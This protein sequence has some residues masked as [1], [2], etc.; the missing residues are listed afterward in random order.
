MFSSMFNF[1]PFVKYKLPVRFSPVYFPAWIINAE[2]EAEVTYQGS[3]RN[4]TAILKSNYLP[5]SSVP[6]LSA[7]R[8]LP[9]GVDDREL[10][11]FTQSLMEQ[12]GLEVNCIPYNISPF[13]ILEIAKSLSYSQATINADLKF[14]PSSVKPHIFS[15]YPILLPLYLA[16]Y[17]MSY[18]NGHK[19]S[20]NIFIQAHSNGGMIMSENFLG[21]LDTPQL[22]AFE[23]LKGL[24]LNTGWADDTEVLEFGMADDSVQVASVSLSPQKDVTR[25]L[26]TY[27]EQPLRDSQNIDKLTEFGEIENDDDPRIRELTPGEVAGIDKYLDISLETM[28]SLSTAS[29]NQKVISISLGSTPKFEMANQ[30]QVTLKTKLEELEREKREAKPGW[31][32]EWEL[33]NRSPAS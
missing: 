32:V 8:L 29:E 20:L 13:S 2:V 21:K 33:G 18:L 11:L 14:S 26:D 23:S 5:G 15:A 31:W 30:A 17:E 1:L 10:P 22:A 24:L 7:A 25:A 12:H 3:T 6:L 28:M 9:Q 16:Q 19:G 27:L 4:A